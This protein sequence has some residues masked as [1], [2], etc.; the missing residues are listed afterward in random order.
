MPPYGSRGANAPKT[1]G[2]PVHPARATAGRPYGYRRH[3]P[4]SNAAPD[5]NNFFSSAANIPSSSAANTIM[6]VINRASFGLMTSFY[7][8]TCP[9]NFSAFLKNGRF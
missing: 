6:S 9:K 4:P 5:Q 3:A 7:A 1:A 2:N 8:K